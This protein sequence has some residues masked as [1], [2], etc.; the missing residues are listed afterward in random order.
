[1]TGYTKKLVKDSPL[2]RKYRCREAHGCARATINSFFCY[3]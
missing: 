1:M 2:Y 3:F